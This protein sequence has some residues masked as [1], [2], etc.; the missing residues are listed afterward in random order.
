MKLK[1]FIHPGTNR[2]GMEIKFFVG[3]DF[4]GT[5]VANKLLIAREHNIPI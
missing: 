1:S 3:D 2:P 4:V 5:K